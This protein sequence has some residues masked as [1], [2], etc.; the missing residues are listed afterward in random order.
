MPK[1][2]RLK[3]KIIV[4]S[5]LPY[6]NNIPHLG[7]LVCIISADVYARFLRLKKESIIFI[8]GT[9]EHGTTTEVKALEE[10]L[11]PKQLVDKYF[12]IHKKIYES[13]NCSFDCF[14]RTTSDEN[15]KITIDIFKKLDKNKFI[16]E[17]ELEQSFC[18][19]CS[20]F[21]ADRFI[22]GKCPHCGYEHARG[23]QCENCGKLLNAIDLV[24][25]KCKICSSTPAIRKSKNLFIDLPK[26]EPEL[27][28]LIRTTEKKWSSNA[29]T[30]T[31]AWLREGLKPRCITRD[32]KWG[33]KVPKKGFEDKVFYSWFDA[34]IGY[35]GITAGNRKDWKKWWHNNENTTLIQFMGKDNIPFHS[36][37][38]PSFLIGSKDNYTLLDALSVNEYIN[39][40][41]GQFSKSLSRGV[42]ADDA[43]STGIKTDI[44]RYYLMI[45]RP[46]K[47]DTEFLWDDFQAKINNE[48]VA[49][50][51]NFVY[52]TLSFTNRFFKSKIPDF[53]LKEE[54]KKFL[55]L[56]KSSEKK[57]DEF[58]ENIKLKD[59]LKEI[60]HI[61][62][63]SNNYFQK[64]EP[65]RTFREDKKKAEAT[66][67]L[68]ANVVKDL[69]I[70]I[71][72]FM[73]S[74][75]DEIKD[76]LN[77][78]KT[79]FNDLGKISLKNYKI[80][81]AKIL[82][83]KLEDK[84]VENL[85][86][87]YSGKKENQVKKNK[88]EFPLDLKVAQ[89]TEVKD[90]PKA[91]RLFIL[92]IDLGKEKR[93][94]VAGL[95]GYYSKNELLNKKII[96]VVNLQPA[97]LRGIR[98]EGMLLAAEDKGKVGLLTA[99]K[100]NAGDNV[101]FNGLINN[102]KEISFDDFKKIKMTVSSGKVIYNSRIMKTDKEEI[103]V[104]RVSDG[105]CV[106]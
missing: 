94:L 78:K 45:N 30:M 59:A 32:I 24:N 7:T 76:Q 2:S 10:N 18:K 34:P 70:L 39:Y 96:V 68:L 15:K 69:S 19:K 84:E 75:A 100:S 35:I 43:L 51:G 5:A 55:S 65:W 98:S 83:K 105:A 21:L 25:A 38:F 104:E 106:S 47:T 99:E 101:C 33:I 93:Q 95:K 31:H 17:D 89:I 79:G 36:I 56:I 49:N 90:H 41:G 42:F 73:P 77:I 14:G 26:I 3:Q 53:K 82:F 87:K 80:K 37:L 20:K 22:E 60:M 85:R 40:E 4:T 86:K 61:S 8:C 50:F 12:K 74:I 23:D 27:R 72:A 54:D 48:L 13:F 58:M 29:V 62:K 44:W 103:I 97:V 102:N 1:K 28:K 64:N 46:E 11:T 67:G 9:D 57:V 16:I 81:K 91:D 66:I 52:R 92:E 6:V 63:L 88:E 71:K